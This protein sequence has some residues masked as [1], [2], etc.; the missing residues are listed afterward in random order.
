[1]K[2]VFAAAGLPV[3]PT[4]DHRPRL[5]RERTPHS[6]ARAGLRYP[7]FVKPARAGSSMGITKVHDAVEG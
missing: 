4:G 1:M 6:P 5:A 7:L 3:G 2:V